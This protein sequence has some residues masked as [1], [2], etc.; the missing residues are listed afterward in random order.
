MISARIAPAR[1]AKGQVGVR[2]YKDLSA[3][4]WHV[5]WPA[6]AL[7]ALPMM[8][9]LAWP[10][11]GSA[12]APAGAGGQPPPVSAQQTPP[13][14]PAPQTQ[15]D[16]TAPRGLQTAAGDAAPAQIAIRPQQPLTPEAV[17]DRII[18]QEQAEVGLVRQYSPLVET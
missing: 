8:A 4:E 6:P 13:P 14:V 2:P 9:L 1:T 16:P 18:A 3:R 5:T 17:L 10:M 11:T 7:L 15:Q 12:Q